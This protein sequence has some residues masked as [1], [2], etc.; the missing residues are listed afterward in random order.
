VK[1]KRVKKYIFKPSN[2]VRWIVVGRTRDYIVLPS[3]GYCSCEDFFFR[4]MSHEK[5]DVLPYSSGQNI[6][7]D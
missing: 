2:R 6:S 1:E 4:V 7:G 5:T 3:V